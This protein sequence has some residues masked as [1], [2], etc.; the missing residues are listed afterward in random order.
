MTIAEG[1]EVASQILQEMEA[2]GT[3]S[4]PEDIE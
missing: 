3:Q 1:K 2:A 4:L